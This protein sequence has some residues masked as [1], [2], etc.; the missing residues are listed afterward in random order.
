MAKTKTSVTMEDLLSKKGSPSI[1]LLNRGD[2]VKGEILSLT[3]R[4]ALVDVGS[5]AEGIIPQRELKGHSLKVGDH[6]FVYV[7]TSE[8]R[9]G[10]IL[11]S[12]NRAQA[13][14]A[15]IDLAEAM[16]K[17]RSLE[18]TVTG[19][20][21]G[22]L[23]VD[24]MGLEGFIPFSHLETAPDLSQDRADLQSQLDRMRGEVLKVQVI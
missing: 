15:W 7:L 21:K 14:R 17:G 20:N 19:H 1:R 24:A 16:E 4:E 13:A 2:V 12:L 10:Q 11:L 18:V 9:R 5:K 6:V 23:A 8:D 3:E 22:G